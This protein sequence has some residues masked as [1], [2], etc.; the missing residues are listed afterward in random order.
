MLRPETLIPFCTTERQKE[1]L[2][3][4]ATESNVSEACRQVNCDRR[5]A[6]RLLKKL[7]E[8]AASQG[9]APHRDL[10]HQT[11]EGFNAKRISTAYKEDGSIALQWVIQEPEK[12]DLRQKIDAM[13]DGLRDD[14]TGFKKPVTAPKEINKDYCA[15]Y[16]VGD[17]H[18]GMLADSDTK[19][20][21][22]D[23]DVKI[24]TKVLIDAVD[25]LS[26]R[27]GNAHTG[28]L[29]NVGDLFHANSGDNKTTAGTPV[30]VDTRIGKTFKL[31]GR[32]FQTIIDKMLEVHQ[33]VVVINVRGNHDSDM[34]C[35]LSSC[36]E[37]LY[38]REPRV[39]VLKNY[40][41]FLH[42]EWENNLFVYHHGDRVKHEQILQAVVTN[43][44]EEWS[45]CKHRYCH[46]GHIHHQMSKEIGT[47]IFEHFSSLTAT[48]QW[49]SDS[50]Y[51]ANRSMTAIVYHKKN[52]EDSR[53]K[54]TID[55]LNDE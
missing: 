20:D 38:D 32:L 37:L 21:D 6:Y 28:V 42:W 4:L 53:V 17:H 19:F 2:S 39:N 48:D 8:K 54:I 29:V 31:A 18:F 22:A 51:G 26:S 16:L 35:H 1:I 12:R 27:V 9:V 33:E 52:G 47:M 44:D 36:L 30:D 55:G 5:Y 15:Q 41:K 34:A 10:T 50:G 3:A 24:A 14:L 46:M 7:E 49:H 13:V 25:R 11:A 23:W 45:R 43:L 40:S